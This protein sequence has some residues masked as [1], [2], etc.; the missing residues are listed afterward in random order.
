MIYG[1]VII[2]K[3]PVFYNQNNISLYF[4]AKIILIE[5]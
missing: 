1:S 3:F 5:R 4:I 2:V